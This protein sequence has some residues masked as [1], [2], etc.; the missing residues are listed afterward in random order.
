LRVLLVVK[1][2]FMESLGPMYLKSVIQHNCHHECLITDL[3]NAIATAESFQPHII[4]YSIMT[5]DMEKFRGLNMNIPSMPVSIVGGPD[6]TFFP[7]GYKWADMVIPGEAEQIMADLLRTGQVYGDLDSLPWPARDDYPGM[8][9]RDFIASRGCTYGKCGYCYNSTWERL[10]PDLPKLRV[11]SAR[12][13][14][15]EV[16]STNP[17]FVYFQDSTFGLSHEWLREF[18]RLYAVYVKAPYHVHLRPNQVTDERASLLAGS[19]CVSMKMALETASDRL[20]KLINRG[21]STN[22]HALAASD[23]LRKYGVACILQNIL[24]LP[25][26]TIEDDLYTLEINIRC[27]PAYAWSSIFQPYPMTELAQICEREGWY[28]GDYSEISDNFFD[29]SVLSFTDEHKEQ[30]VCLQRVFAFCVE[31]QTMPEV[32][33]LTYATLPKFIHNT[34]RKIGDR[35]MFANAL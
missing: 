20:R 29:N 2:K 23:V 27:R 18:A 4:G 21:N 11:R 10:Y 3:P 26:A 33:D 7:E 34:M 13:V 25:S 31:T 22:E 9:V 14:V 32:K 30:I 35:R 12:D 24:G 16:A 6:P 8:K 28:T 17:E 1:T 19:G 5:G 15:N